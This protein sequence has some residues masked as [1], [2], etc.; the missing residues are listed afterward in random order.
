[1][2]GALNGPILGAGTR[3]VFFVIVMAVPDHP[4]VDEG[5]DV[6]VSMTCVDRASR[7]SAPRLAI[8][9]REGASHED[10]QLDAK[11][12]GRIHADLTSGAD[13]STAVP[14]KA[15]EG[16]SFQGM[17]LVG[18]GFRLTREQISALG[19]DA[20]M[21]PAQIRPYL[22]AQELARTRQSRFVIDAYGLTAEELRNQ[23]PA[24]YQ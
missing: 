15:N 5:A 7:V 14:L 16:V 9:A 10:V 1:M 23:H 22:N 3:M 11:L 20:D 17:N 4:W 24:L 2:H 18:K 8:V 6:R 19:Y 13:V 12:V 21:L